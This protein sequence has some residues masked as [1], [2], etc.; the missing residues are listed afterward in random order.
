MTSSGYKR[1]LATAAVSAMAI[2][3]LPFFAGAANADTLNNQAGGANA[4]DLVTFDGHTSTTTVS[5]KN[6]G[7]NTTFRLEAVAGANVAQVRF[8]YQFGAAAPTTIATVSRND[9]GAFMT[10]WSA[11]GLSGANLTIS[12]VGLAADGSTIGTDSHAATVDNA[13]ETVNVTDGTAMGVFQAPYAGHS[14]NFVSIAG[15]AS[16]NDPVDLE[17]YDTGGFVA[18]GGATP[19]GANHAWSQVI[20]ITGYTFSTPD[21]L[22]VSADNGDSDD[23]EAYTLYKQQITTVTAVPDRTMVPSG[24]AATITVTV[25]DQNGKPIA[26]A[27]VFSSSGGAAAYTDQ[28]GQAV[29]HQNG[30]SANN[31]YYYANA[32]NSAAY[33]PELGDKKSD[34]IAIGQYQPA[35]TSLAASSL[36]GAAFDHD[37]YQA[38]NITVQVKD[39][40]SN[41]Y[42]T[43]N[44]SLNYYW[45]F[46]P[47]GGGATVRTPV[48]GTTAQPTETGGKFVVGAPSNGFAADGTYEL[49]GSLSQDS[50]GNGA[51]AESKLLTVSSG[52]AEIVFDQS[53]PQQAVIGGEIT[54]HGMLQLWAGGPGL[55]GRPIHVT[56]A[57]GNAL[58][59][60]DTG[61]DA[62]TYDTKTDATG[63]FSAVLDDPNGDTTAENDTVTAAT[64]PWTHDSE[65][66]NAGASG[67]QTASFIKSVTP[68]EVTVTQDASQQ[69]NTN[70]ELQPGELARYTVCAYSDSDPNTAG[71]QRQLLTNT[72]V[73]VAVD[74]GY[75]TDGVATP[76]AAANGPVGTWDND[77][78]TKKVMTG[79]NGCVIVWT[80]IGK[81]AGFDDD[82]DV[83]AKVTGTAGTATGSATAAWTSE[84]PLNGGPV[85]VDFASA[86]QQTSDMLPK[87]QAG[88]EYVS[89]QEVKL[90]VKAFDQ[91]GNRVGGESVSLA[92][93]TNS[94]TVN[95]PVV[96][97]YNDQSDA[98]A[99][100]TGGGDQKITGTWSAPTTLYTNTAGSYANSSKA[101]TDDVTINWYAVDYAASVF[102]LESDAT[103]AMPVGSSVILTYSATDQEGQP[104]KGLD[105]G[106][107][108]TGPDQYQDGDFNSFDMTDADGLARYVF[109]GAA[110]GTATITAI[111]GDYH[112]MS[113]SPIGDSRATTTVDFKQQKEPISVTLSGS[114]NGGK[115]DVLKVDTDSAA[116]GAQVT[117]YKVKKDG[118]KVALAN[119]VIDSNGKHK[120]VVDD[121]NGNDPTKYVA[122]VFKTNVTKAAWSNRDSVR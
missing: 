79:S 84:H 22:L 6:D 99:T 100:A 56:N 115:D 11:A 75:F 43:T 121:K 55:P 70:T 26:G 38:G 114:D 28:N 48:S 72:E 1:G 40:Q 67:S 39:Q 116:A 96:T 13:A 52:D 98:S 111:A 2:T 110:A 3:G 117:L 51:I 5:M 34:T 45:I 29:F 77:G 113:F 21:Q 89:G 32:T 78:Q 92:D 33:E 57:G 80:S 64:A 17:W 31:A 4:V 42:D 109:Q 88:D 104:I 49:F 76:A 74:H 44:Q 41:P 85:T 86:D 10:E 35:P 58:F 71:V 36:D 62:A 108:R 106:F 66:D 122:K 65:T 7:Q 24:S 53:P 23:T 95:S 15:T 81:D 47:A 87:A 8:Q 60:Q 102:T 20:D 94:A 27:Q 118:T 59:N 107:M 30:G 83:T 25:T 103:G 14:G 120:F 105:V 63:K 61:P 112:T 46:T 90:V 18:D 97:D 50:L 68:A 82:G 101:Q 12:A 19:A 16:S 37:E 54:L 73:T 91:F 119:G 93:N 9:D 69:F